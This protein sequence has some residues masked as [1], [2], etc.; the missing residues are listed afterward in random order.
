MKD[1]IS[2]D[3]RR[4][5]LLFLIVLA[6]VYASVLM[7]WITE[8][9]PGVTADSVIYIEAARSLLAGNGLVVQDRAMTHFPPVYPLLLSVVGLLLEGNI[10]LASRLLAALLFGVNLVL[11]CLAVQVCTRHSLA[12]TG[13]AMFV[14]LFS[15]PIISIHSMAMSEAPFITFST[16]AF[17]LL[18]YHIVRPTPY[19]LVLASLMAGLAA[20]TRYVGIVLFPTMAIALLLLGNRPIK[21]KLRDVI[22]FAGIA[23]LPL[24]S[25]FIR[26][27][28]IAQTVANR[29]ITFHP[30]SLSHAKQLIITMYD[31][32]LTTR[33]GAKLFI[34]AYG[35]SDPNATTVA[36]LCEEGLSISARLMTL[37]LV[38]AVV[39]FFLGL[40]LLRRTMYIKR[41]GASVGIVLPAL[42]IFYSLAYVA[43][44]IITISFVDA[45][46]PVDHRLLL[47]TFLAFAVAGISLAWSVSEALCQRYVWYSFVLFVLFSVSINSGNAISIASYLHENGSGYTSQTWKHSEILF[48]LSE[49]RDGSEIYSNGADIIR[50]L[51]GRQAVMIPQKIFPR[52]RRSNENYEEQVSQMVRE[53]RE[54]RALFVYLNNVTWRWYLPSIKEVESIAKLPVLRRM[55][56]GVIYG[57]R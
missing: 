14:F 52:T 20:A 49:V 31:F 7:Y 27:V 11:F 32:V 42:C 38:V 25:W 48:Y 22:V 5:R 29:E 50:F 19:L 23:V 51:T 35:P 56:D 37:H 57:T 8:Q 47:P 18:A 9:G 4:F 39:L 46:T 34:C 33:A 44:L 21:H 30:F 6:G 16:A 12:A 45:H 3:R 10:L 55:Q 17:L 1:T 13:C 53:C 41:N 36:D 15:A 28:V 26:N 2:A 40:I 54:G 24:A 43:F